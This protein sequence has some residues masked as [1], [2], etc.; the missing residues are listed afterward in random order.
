MGYNQTMFGFAPYGRYW[1]DMR[2]LVM[3]E[4]LSNHRLELLK[5]VRD[6]ET[7][8]LMKDFYEK[9]SRNGGQVVVE[10]K[11]RLA[12][13]ATNITVRMISGKRY[14]SADAKGNQEAKRLCT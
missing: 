3:V 5:H 8:L 14:F 10:M 12:E 13:M 2:K 4:L 7:S 6:T 1:R 9:S 11:Q